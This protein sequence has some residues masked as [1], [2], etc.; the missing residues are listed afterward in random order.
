MHDTVRKIL[1]FVITMLILC[2]VFLRLV[3][4][5][6]AYAYTPSSDLWKI[7]PDSSLESALDGCATVPDQTL[8]GNTPV[9]LY[10]KI[11]CYDPTA[12][13]FHRIYIYGDD[14]CSLSLS[15]GRYSF[16]GRFILSRRNFVRGNTF[17][18]DLTTSCSELPA[19]RLMYFDNPLNPTCS[20]SATEILYKS[21][22]S[23]RYISFTWVQAPP[24]TTDDISLSDLGIIIPDPAT[25]ITGGILS[26]V[27]VIAQR[28]V[29]LPGTIVDGIGNGL[30][31]V[32]DGIVNA[33]GNIASAI[34]SILETLFIPEE[35][36]NFE[37][38][39]EDISN[40][41][42]VIE[43]L[44]DIVGTLFDFDD[45]DTPPEFNVTLFGV[46]V[47]IFSLS[48][49]VAIRL[50]VRGVVILFAY[51]G[52]FKWLVHFMPSLLAGIGGVSK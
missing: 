22:S 33:V 43:Q 29:T 45:T 3:V 46:E 39:K 48:A 28:I 38:I 6:I 47:S 21:G 15:N 24:D 50:L 17:Q 37:E 36:S 35:I 12:N 8:A 2:T 42:P 13:E 51:I 14:D 44:G 32:K 41:F 20:N 52:F 34:G 18:Y 11:S 27:R 5:D 26:Q 4:S 7:Q 23:Y 30:T 1:V 31:A 10:F 49:F 40:K 16:T 25:E 9:T 19:S